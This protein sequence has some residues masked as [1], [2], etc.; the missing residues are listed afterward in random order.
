[1]G[2]AGAAG[3]SGTAIKCLGE[4]SGVDKPKDNFSISYLDID[5]LKTRLSDLS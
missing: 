5:R 1:M 3:A 2:A 4:K